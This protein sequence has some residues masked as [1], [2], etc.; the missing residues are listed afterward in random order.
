MSSPLGIDDS[1]LQDI[2]EEDTIIGVLR[3]FGKKLENDLKDN[4]AKHDSSDLG[5]LEQSILFDLEFPS[6]DVIRFIVRYNFYGDFINKGVQGIGGARKTNSKF[7]G[8]KGQVFTNKAPNSTFKFKKNKPLSGKMFTGWAK[9]KGLSPWAVAQSL[10][11][12][13]IKPNHWIDEV[14]TDNFVTSLAQALGIAGAKEI[15]IALVNGI[16]QGSIRK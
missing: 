10:W 11:K 9:R 2:S 6:E 15:E 3:K 14:Y 8:K 12:S 7:G 5:S 16:L 4:L 1:L 13:G